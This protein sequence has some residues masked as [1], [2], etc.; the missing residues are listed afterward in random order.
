THEDAYPYL[1]GK[2]WLPPFRVRRIVEM[3]TETG[4]HSPDTFAR[5]QMDTVSV[6][7]RRIVPFLLEVEPRSDRQKEALS[8]LGEWNGDLDADSVAACLYEVWGKH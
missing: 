3:I 5:M 4:L 7:A 6:P 8:Y 2:D 1:I